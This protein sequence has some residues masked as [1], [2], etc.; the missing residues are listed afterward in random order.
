MFI[1]FKYWPALQHPNTS[2]TIGFRFFIALII[3]LSFYTQ[4]AFAEPL[5]VNGGRS[6]PLYKHLEMTTPPDILFT[7]SDASPADSRHVW[8][9]LDLQRSPFSSQHWLIRFRQ[10]PFQQLD[11]FSPTSSGYQLNK[12]GTDRQNKSGARHTVQLDLST[13]SKTFYIRYQSLSPNRLAPELWPVEA[14]QQQQNNRNLI[15]SSFQLLLMVM[16]LLIFFQ[17]FRHQTSTSYLMIS[18]TLAASALLLFWQGDVFINLPW[19]GDPGHWVAIMT[20]LV[21]TISITSYRQLTALATYTPLIDKLILTSCTLAL[22]M[23]VYFFSQADRLPPVILETAVQTLSVSYLLIILGSIH[24][25]YNGSHPA[26]STLITAGLTLLALTLSW[27]YEPWPRSLPSHPELIILSL[28]ACILPAIHWYQLYLSESKGMAINIVNTNDRKRRIYE[29][30]LRQHLQ[31]PDSTLSESE[32]PNRVLLTLEEVVPQ[33]PAIILIFSDDDWQMVGELSKSAQQLRGQLSSIQ[34]DLLQVITTDQ[35]TKINFKDRFGHFYWLFPL[36]QENN[37]TVLLAM[38]PSRT[39]RTPSAWQTACD[40]SSHARTLLQASQQ[41]QFWQQQAC[42]DSLTGLLNRRAFC[43]E[44]EQQIRKSFV[45]K[46]VPPCCALFID[47]DH[48]KRINDRHGHAKGDHMLKQTAKVCRQVL[49]HQDLLGRYGGE[50]FVALLPNTEP[51]QALHVAERI[52]R[53]IAETEA[54]Q[55]YGQI[56][57]SIGLAALSH[58]VGTLDQLLEE[59]DKA[60]YLAKEQ[61]RNQ[62]CISPDLQDARLPS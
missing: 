2:Q 52:R 15:I 5:L 40:I 47:I 8:Y 4:R 23:T 57:L 62:T 12:L 46:E 39:Q 13:D 33:I 24:C 37:K 10:V 50:E 34:E 16:L 56:T 30:A 60:M 26:R 58:H 19:L 43:Q 54:L 36:S 44:A 27:R 9:K 17:H 38:A 53:R 29:S 45:S 18:H 21:L 3:C 49:R 48:F 14:Y 32:I 35:D 6:I 20:I 11:F 31:N 59:A 22:T 55:E 25:L 7:S 42:L 41:S 51:W 28:Q 1:S 61:G